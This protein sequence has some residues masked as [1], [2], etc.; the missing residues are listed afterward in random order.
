MATASC[1]LYFYALSYKQIKSLQVA[2]EIIL[3]QAIISS[4]IWPDLINRKNN[5]AIIFTISL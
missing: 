2:G 1:P 3:N 5:V 4:Q